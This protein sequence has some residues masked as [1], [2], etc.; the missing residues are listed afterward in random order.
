MKNNSQ[1][2][3]AIVESMVDMVIIT[4]HEGIIN[5]ASPQWEALLG[6][7]PSEMIGKRRW[8]FMNEEETKKLQEKF[9]PYFNRRIPFYLL[10]HSLTH[11]DGHRIVVESS[12]TPIFDSH[13]EFNGYRVSNRDITNRSLLEDFSSQM[14]EDAYATLLRYQEVITKTSKMFMDS[15]FDQLDHA[16]NQSLTEVGNLLNICRVYIFEFDAGA[17]TISN[18]YEWCANG[19]ESTMD[20]FQ[21]MNVNSFPWLMRKLQN[22]EIINIFDVNKMGKV[23]IH[24]KRIFQQHYIQSVLIVP[25]HVNQ[26]LIGSI[27]FYS[28]LKKKQFQDEIHLIQMFSEIVGYAIGKRNDEHRILVS[29][30]QLKTTFTQTIEAL[31]EL[32]EISDPYTSGHQRKVAQL[33]L[34]IAKYLEFSQE[35]QD[36]LYMAAVLHD[37]GK[38]YVPAQIL[39]KPGKLTSIEFDL[40]KTHVEYG[41]Q[42]LKKIDFPWPIAK[43]VHQHHERV[44][45]SGYPFG[46]KGDE[47]LIEAQIISV[48]DV[49]EAISSHRPY[50]PAIGIDFAIEEI[51]RL[52]GI[53]F[54]SEIVDACVYL[55]ENKLFHFEE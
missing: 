53:H 24:E 21:E 28:V 38:S 8:D 51:K 44:D 6:Y 11:K 50:R 48:A 4:D 30:Q 13:G 36:A 29:L 10:T 37:L 52:K 5:Y 23:Q 27:G 46:L 17:Q 42:V 49:I 39:N 19:V 25:M 26:K 40:V 18:T 45:G 47:I 3:K 54:K 2:Y 7:H 41:Y 22:N 1:D 14:K 32:V 20:Q 9:F 15:P 43:M 31:S 35:Q 12:G 16:I 55:F 33:S 34:A